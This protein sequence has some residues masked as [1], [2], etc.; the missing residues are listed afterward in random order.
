M[1]F[2]ESTIEKLNQQIDLLKAYQPHSAI[3][4]SLN[5]G[6]MKTKIC[7]PLFFVYI[8]FTRLIHR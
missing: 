2:S 3:N 8:N 4:K 6:T 5:V 7:P 1:N